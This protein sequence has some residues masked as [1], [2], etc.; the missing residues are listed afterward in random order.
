MHVRKITSHLI[1]DEGRAEKKKR[2]FLIFFIAF[3]FHGL[4]TMHSEAL[5]HS[6]NK[7]NQ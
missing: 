3:S 2:L 5:R 1:S 7:E 4:D 6:R